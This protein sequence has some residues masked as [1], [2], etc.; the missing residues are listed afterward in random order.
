MKAYYIS[1]KIDGKFIK[2]GVVKDFERDD[3]KVKLELTDAEI[4]A[5]Y[6]AMKDGKL[7]KGSYNERHYNEIYA[8]TW[9][10]KG[11]KS[12]MPQASVKS[13]QDVLNGDDI[14]F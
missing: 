2:F 9:K 12:T 8:E 6:E 7:K 1:Q 10:D 11:T 3:G 13:T 14:P 5:L 4:T